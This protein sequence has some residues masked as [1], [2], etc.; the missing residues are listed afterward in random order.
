MPVV[1]CLTAASGAGLPGEAS[2]QGE[3]NIRKDTAGKV[4]YN[5]QFCVY[6]IQKLSQA[7]GVITCA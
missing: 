5:W 4:V 2:Q 3:T 6:N 7:T 1:G